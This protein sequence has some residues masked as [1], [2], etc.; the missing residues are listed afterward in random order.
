MDFGAETPL[1]G[2]HGR[3]RT[4]SASCQQLS[5]HQEQVAEGKEREELCPVLGQPAIAGLY[6]A[7]LTLDHTEG[8]L[9]LCGAGRQAMHHAA[10]GIDADMR[11]HAKEPRV[12][13][14]RR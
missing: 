3:S 8:M 6:V 5:S 4:D 7:E 13:L 14:L 1:S 10:L 9:D 11:F 12:A 2:R